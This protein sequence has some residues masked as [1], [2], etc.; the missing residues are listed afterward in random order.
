MVADLAAVD[1]Q[2]A[3]VVG[4]AGAEALVAAAHQAVGEDE[5]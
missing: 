5:T 1:F 2:V 3:V 4:R